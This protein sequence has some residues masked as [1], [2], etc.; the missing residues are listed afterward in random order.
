MHLNARCHLSLLNIRVGFLFVINDH[1]P[2]NSIV[3]CNR[4]IRF[5]QQP[6]G[7]VTTSTNLRALLSFVVASAIESKSLSITTMQTYESPNTAS[8]TFDHQ[9]KP[10]TTETRAKRFLTSL[11]L[12]SLIF[13]PNQ[14][15][16]SHHT[17][18][19]WTFHLLF[20]RFQVLC[21]IGD[22]THSCINK[23]IFSWPFHHIWLGLT[24]NSSNR[25][26]HSI[27]WG[28]LLKYMG[29]SLIFL[30]HWWWF[31]SLFLT[32]DNLIQSI[33]LIVLWQLDLWHPWQSHST[34]YY[35]IVD[36]IHI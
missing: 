14:N 1:A 20:I 10:T 22:L 18:S 2:L 36:D 8:I 3:A 13:F 9:T 30:S 31:D 7:F 28:I 6:T 27:I 25:D 16:L 26:F 5:D 34:L 35:Y 4:P 32:N 17:H 24:C 33:F 19:K 29:F 15:K 11:Y 12:H 23:L 21:S